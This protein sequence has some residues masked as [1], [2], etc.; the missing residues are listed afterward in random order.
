MG[1]HKSLQTMNTLKSLMLAM[2]AM[3]AYITAQDA[4]A[5]DGWQDGWCN[6]KSGADQNSGEKSLG[7]KDSKEQCLLECKK[8]AGAT[9]C[10]I[11]PGEACIVHTQEVGAGSGDSPYQ[12]FVFSGWQD[13]WCNDKS[14]A[15]QNSGEKSLGAKDSKE[16]CLLE[17]KKEAGATGCEIKPGE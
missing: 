6:D 12:C 15:D 9:G 7:A 14:G 4:P 11:K 5:V 2:L 16:Q 8:E 10:E 1:T 13:G 17:C 3:V